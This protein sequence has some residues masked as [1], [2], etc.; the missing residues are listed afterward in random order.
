MSKYHQLILP[1]LECAIQSLFH[2]TKHVYDCKKH[3]R[4]INMLLKIVQIR[5]Y[6]VGVKLTQASQIKLTFVNSLIKSM[7]FNK[8]LSGFQYIRYYYV[9]AEWFPIQL[10]KRN[11][12]I[13]RQP[14]PQ[15][16]VQ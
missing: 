5:N 13:Y 8:I 16:I 15:L 3:K 4:L 6:M 14:C 12:G 2:V 9:A 7:L 1:L 10:N 11:N